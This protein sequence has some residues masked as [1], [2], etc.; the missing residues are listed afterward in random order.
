MSVKIGVE[1]GSAVG[2][3][4]NAMLNTDHNEHIRVA[5]GFNDE[6]TIILNS[7]TIAAGLLG[8]EHPACG[9]ILELKRS[10]ARCTELS[11]RLTQKRGQTQFSRPPV[12][13]K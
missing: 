1:A 6:L 10:A 5:H 12:E 7:A 2:L 3:R 13:P 11:R 8:P 9:A 4:L